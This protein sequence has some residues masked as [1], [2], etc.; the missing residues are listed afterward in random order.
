MAIRKALE[1]DC[2]SIRRVAETTWHHTYEGIIPLGIQERFLK[3]AYSD[4]SLEKRIGASLFLVAEENGEVAGF[5]NFSGVDEGYSAN[6]YAIYVLPAFQGRKIGSALL[7]EGMRNYAGLQSLTVDVEKENRAGLHFYK[8]KGFQ[9]I[10][11]FTEDL[12]GH[13]LQTVRM[14]RTLIDGKDGQ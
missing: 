12:Y 11:E 13:S 9:K 7:E 10:K 5:A 8:A 1:D 4:G 3:E 6:L 14:K 2:R